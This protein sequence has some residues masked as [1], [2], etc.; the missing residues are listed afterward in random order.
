MAAL[1]SDSINVLESSEA[2]SY[3]DSIMLT[4]RATKVNSPLTNGKKRHLSLPGSYDSSAKKL[5]NDTSGESDDESAL[6]DLFG[7]DLEETKRKVA[8][9]KQKQKKSK[10]SAR[11]IFRTGAEVHNDSSADDTSVKQL[12]SALSADMHMMYNSLHDRIDKFEAGLEQRISNKVAQLL[13]KRVNTELNRIKKDVDDRVETFKETFRAEIDEDLNELNNKLNNMNVQTPDTSYDRSLNIAIRG[14]PESDNE[15]L[16]NKVNS[17]IKD[18]LSVRNVAVKTV[19]RK[20]SKIQSKP[21]VI[22]ASFKSVEDKRKVMV[23]KSKLRDSRQYRDV[24]I[25]HDQSHEQRIM[26]SNFKTV[27]SALNDNDV[28]LALRGSRIVRRDQQD[29]QVRQDQRREQSLQRREPSGSENVRSTNNHS[30]RGQNDSNRRNVARRGY[31]RGRNYV[32]RGDR[33]GYGG[34]NA[35]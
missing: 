28:N 20:Q 35:Y 29:Q 21:G 4:Q 16:S 3:V 31:G 24:Y 34:H 26:A 10:S 23:E 14:L 9:Q 22:I 18:G 2:E 27:L 25:H 1:I 19:V 5:R 33:G 6:G 32:G 7:D 17:V 8:K 30:R 13:D 11:N 15:N 12:L